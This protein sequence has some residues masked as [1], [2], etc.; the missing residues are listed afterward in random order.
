MPD[1]NPTT[2]KGEM[3]DFWIYSSEEDDFHSSI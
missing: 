2:V 3:A 1:R